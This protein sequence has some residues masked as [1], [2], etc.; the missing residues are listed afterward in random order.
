MKK[1]KKC[2]KGIIACI[3]LLNH[4][5]PSQS[6]RTLI[7]VINYKQMINIDNA[8]FSCKLSKNKKK[9][10]SLGGV[11]KLLLFVIPRKQEHNAFIFA[12]SRYDITMLSRACH[13]NFNN[14]DFFFHIFNKRK[15]N[16][17]TLHNPRNKIP[18]KYKNK[19]KK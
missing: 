1:P 10:K 7:S 14:M 12:Q 6:I 18:G 3:H 19:N 8:T 17:T 5:S 9:P 15:S 4:Q 11:E 16:N 13:S 2:S